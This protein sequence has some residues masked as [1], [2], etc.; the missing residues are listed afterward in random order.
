MCWSEP[1]RSS[2]RSRRY[3]AVDVP[4]VL[5]VGGGTNSERGRILESR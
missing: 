3:L 2:A 5:R 4:Y 1:S